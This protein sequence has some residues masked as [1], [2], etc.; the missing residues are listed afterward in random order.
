[1]T[2]DEKARARRI[3][4]RFQGLR[5]E[6]K[7]YTL[8]ISDYG[9]PSMLPTPGWHGFWTA[10]H[11]IQLTR[12]IHSEQ[13]MGYPGH[14]EEPGSSPNNPTVA[15]VHPTNFAW[16][17][18]IKRDGMAELKIGIEAPPGFVDDSPDAYSWHDEE[19]RKLTFLP[20]N[21]PL[22]PPLKR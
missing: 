7:M 18:F 4:A 8:H 2:P 17:L 15:H 5:D 22:V 21:H 20:P 16:M 6:D 13:T 11:K 9:V 1:M 10:N 3:V 14:P 19:G 12:R